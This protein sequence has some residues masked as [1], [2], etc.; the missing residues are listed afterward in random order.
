MRQLDNL[1]DRDDDSDIEYNILKE[2]N[3]EEAESVF[4]ISYWCLFMWYW[5]NVEI[6]VL[7]ICDSDYSSSG[8]TI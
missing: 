5:E 8:I 4:E 6:F 7:S 2:H 3:T 1:V